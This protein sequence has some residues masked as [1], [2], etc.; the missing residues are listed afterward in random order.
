MRRAIVLLLVGLLFVGCG[1]EGNDDDDDVNK[2]SPVK[3]ETVKTPFDTHPPERTKLPIIVK[4][5]PPPVPEDI[6]AVTG[7]VLHRI[8]FVLEDESKRFRSLHIMSSS[9]RRVVEL[10][11]NN[12]EQDPAWSWDRQWVAYLSQ[13]RGGDPFD[14]YLV[15]PDDA[16]HV[17]LTRAGTSIEHPSWSPDGGKIAYAQNWDIY[18]MNANGTHPV[19]LTRNGAGNMQPNWSPNGRRIVFS[20]YL[21]NDGYSSLFVIDVDGTNWKRLTDAPRSYDELPDWS[22]NNRAIAF[23][24]H[25]G[26]NWSIFTIKPNGQGLTQLTDSH[27]DCRHPSWSPDSERIAFEFYDW[28]ANR[29]IDIYTMNADGTDQINI[30]N[31]PQIETQP[32]W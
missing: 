9:G 20:S 8:A 4:D 18:V 15:S 16:R 3:T 19:N 5:I 29:N 2:G 22:P 25:S 17:R 31:S 6:P 1:D 26:E 11:D 24:R 28:V 23:M 12:F 10:I 13:A 32:T 21:N 27:H 7:K 14:L 30:T